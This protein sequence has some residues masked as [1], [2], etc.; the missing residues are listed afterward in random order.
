[1]LAA[2]ISAGVSS[3]SKEQAPASPTQSIPAKRPSGPSEKDRFI[4][5][6]IGGGISRYAAAWITGPLDTIRST[7]QN[8]NSQ[9]VVANLRLIA[10]EGPRKMARTL[11]SPVPALAL[12]D[13]LK[14]ISRFWS[15]SFVEDLACSAMG[16]NKSNLTPNQRSRINYLSGFIGAFCVESPVTAVPETLQIYKS[17]AG[18]ELARAA[19]QRASSHT[20][21]TLKAIVVRSNVWLV[22]DMRRFIPTKTVITAG[23]LPV[24]VR[25]GAFAGA[26]FWGQGKA[27]E[28]MGPCPEPLL[29][30]LSYHFVAGTISAVPSVLFSVPFQ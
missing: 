14:G 8:G 22:N 16:L 23:I 6:G 30:K 12:K 9:S 20:L 25:N 18:I 7:A 19:T 29:Q 27:E 21:D 2:G 26:M 28:L 4:N 24:A 5:E 3:S 1:M 13:G 15:K 17:T 10:A 11:Y